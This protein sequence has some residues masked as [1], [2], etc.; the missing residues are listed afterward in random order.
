MITTR[1]LSAHSS[2]VAPDVEAPLQAVSP[3]PVL[4]T[5]H[6]VAFVTAAAVPVSSPTT[7]RWIEVI[8]AA[9]VAAC[10]MLRTPTADTRP[11]P[12]DC[13]RRYT[14]LENAL[15]SREMDRL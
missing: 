5:E 3:A 11:V 4:I 1:Q 6:Q 10:G 2:D 9:C 15:M 8:H 12:S 14:F 7:R 13:L